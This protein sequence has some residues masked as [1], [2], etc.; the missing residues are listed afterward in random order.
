MTLSRITYNPCD[1]Y[2][3]DV[4]PHLAVT[5]KRLASHDGP[6]EGH[7][8]QGKAY[9]WQWGEATAAAINREARTATFD[10]ALGLA[11]DQWPGEALYWVTPRGFMI[12]AR[13]H[14]ATCAVYGHGQGVYVTLQHLLI[15]D[16]RGRVKPCHLCG[17]WRP[18]Y[19]DPEPTQ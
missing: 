7:D 10:F 12:R 6:H 15:L 19:L 2:S 16:P 11:S 13:T 9:H 14:N 5:C 4:F 3:G 17:G 8:D 18:F 1:A